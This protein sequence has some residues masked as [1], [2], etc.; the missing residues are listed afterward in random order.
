MEGYIG[1]QGTPHLVGSDGIDGL[2]GESSCRK[3]ND[4]DDDDDDKS[5]VKAAA[6]GVVAMLSVCRERDFRQ[7]MNSKAARPL[8]DGVGRSGLCLFFAMGALVTMDVVASRL[9]T[10]RFRS[11]RGMLFVVLSF[12]SN[13][14]RNGNTSPNQQEQ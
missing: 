2:F 14:K 11:F 1:A 7:P 6:R 9:L 5:V 13:N 10:P 3:E 8:R 12:L 4:D